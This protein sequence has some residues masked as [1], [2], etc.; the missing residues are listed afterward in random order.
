MGYFQHSG[1]DPVTLFKK[2]SREG[3]T[4]AKNARK[5]LE[6]KTKQKV[7]TKENY[8]IEQEKKKRIRG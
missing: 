4:I 6:K 3:G 2:V 7:I 8:L 1:S 5:A